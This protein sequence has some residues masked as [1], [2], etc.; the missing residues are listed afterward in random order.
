MSQSPHPK[1]DPV[2]IREFVADLGPE[3]DLTYLSSV[4]GEE[5]M[6]AHH[7]IQKTGLVLTGFLD[8]L[9]PERVQVFGPSEMNHLEREGR[10]LRTV[11][12]DP[13][14]EDVPAILISRGLPAPTLLLDLSDRFGIP[15]IGTERST[16]EM[17]GRVLHYLGTRLAPRLLIH[18]VVLDLFG[19]GVLLLGES[20]IGK[21][22][23]ALELVRRGHRMVADDVVEMRLVEGT[24]HGCSP[25]MSRN[26][27]EVRGLGILNIRDVF[28]LTS[29][30]EN[31][32]VSC[33]VRLVK[34]AESSR[35]DRLGNAR[36]T[37][38]ILGSHIPLSEIPVAPGRNL[39]TMVEVAVRKHRLSR[40]GGGDSHSLSE[41]LAKRL[42]P[43]ENE[44]RREEE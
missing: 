42:H 9:H 29:V 35:W 23:C 10:R 41:A 20:G 3:L 5:R 19:V 4:R 7:G 24:L 28:G 15:L 6:I 26:Y 21:S 18:G 16:S 12:E 43:Q 40:C 32:V 1:V 30:R 34:F 17:V 22:E 8:N 44:Q 14:W 27:M 2:S 33:A 25:E 37:H 11:L 39:A 36:L 31:I 38:E 13:R